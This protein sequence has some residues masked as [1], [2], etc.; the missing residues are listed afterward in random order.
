[1]KPGDPE[2]DAAVQRTVDSLPPLTQAQRDE[3]TV[4]LRPSWKP[5]PVS[6]RPSG[7][8]RQ[9]RRLEAGYLVAGWAAPEEPGPAVPVEIGSGDVPRSSPDDGGW[10]W[11][12]VI[13]A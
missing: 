2:Y 9:R 5:A 10:G 12:P 3:Y 11:L 8:E 6:G 4:L 1:M 13:S 7:R